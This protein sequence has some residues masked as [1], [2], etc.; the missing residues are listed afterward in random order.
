MYIYIFISFRI[1]MQVHR[2]QPPA[3]RLS[4]V[5]LPHFLL[6]FLLPQLKARRRRQVP[7]LSFDAT[8]ADFCL[9]HEGILSDTWKNTRVKRNSNAAFAQRRFTAKMS[10]VDMNAY[11]D[12]RTIHLFDDL[13]LLMLE[14]EMDSLEEELHREDGE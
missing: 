10:C 5:L 11:M 9:Q 4:L 3:V 12:N 2:L 14:E 7:L 1:N 8:F 6:H 13:S